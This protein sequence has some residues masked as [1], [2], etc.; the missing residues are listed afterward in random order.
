MRAKN[1]EKVSSYKG[2]KEYL[3][4][5]FSAF[6][7]LT[8]STKYECTCIGIEFISVEDDAQVNTYL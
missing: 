1:I 3:F 7:I 4:P 8:C 2:E 5:C 6:K